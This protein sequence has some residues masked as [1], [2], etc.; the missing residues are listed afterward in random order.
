[1][2]VRVG[3]VGLSVSKCAARALRR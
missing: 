2:N 3:Y 1:M